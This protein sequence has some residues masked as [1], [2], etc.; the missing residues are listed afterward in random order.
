MKESKLKLGAKRKFES[1]LASFATTPIG[2]RHN[3]LFGLAKL[4]LWSGIS[5]D[6]LEETLFAAGNYTERERGEIRATIAKAGTDCAQS[7][8]SFV[9]YRPQTRTK[10]TRTPCVAEQTLFRELIQAGGERATFADLR[11]LSPSVVPVAPYAQA[12]A[13]LNALFGDCPHQIWCGNLTDAKKADSVDSLPNWALRIQIGQTIPP[14]L[15]ANPVTGECANGSYRNSGTIAAYRHAVIEIDTLPLA[16]QCAFWAG[17]IKRQL[18]P[19]R[20]LVYSGGKSIHGIIRLTDGK[21]GWRPQWDTLARCLASDPDPN[22]RIDLQ[23]RDSTR[24]SRLAGC[25][26]PDTGT[27][28]ELLWLAE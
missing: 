26:R 12:K 28:Q 1:G 17:I 4:G 21:E 25:R 11:A 3:R 6:E 23:C 14:F 22:Y 15:A 19:L 24:M 20:T 18:L 9:P 8:G 27:I 10:Q 7:G 5:P 13:Q 2:S 16:T